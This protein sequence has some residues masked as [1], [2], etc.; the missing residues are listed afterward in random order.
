MK[1]I[2]ARRANHGGPVYTAV[3]N[4]V[5]PSAPAPTTAHEIPT[6]WSYNWPA[7]ETGQVVWQTDPR[8]SLGSKQTEWDT[9]YMACTR[10]ED[11]AQA[12]WNRRMDNWL[13]T[14]PQ[15]LA[16]MATAIARLGCALNT[17]ADSAS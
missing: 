13:K 17:K 3:P 14:A 5:V 10:H 2:Y 12:E 4:G 1:P 7:T 15:G 9:P 8:Y 11:A 6:G 16:A